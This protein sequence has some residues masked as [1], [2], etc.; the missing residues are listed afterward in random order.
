MHPLSKVTL[1]SG[2]ILISS[3]RQLFQI[4]SHKSKHDDLRENI[5]HMTQFGFKLALYMRTRVKLPLKLLV[6][7][8]NFMTEILT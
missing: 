4:S 2:N 8:K 5:S 1:E 3:Y 7:T 6:R